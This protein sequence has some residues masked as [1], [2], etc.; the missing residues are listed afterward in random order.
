MAETFDYRGDLAEKP[1]AIQPVSTILI[2]AQWGDEGKGKWVDIL[3]RTADFSIRFQG[4]NNAGH[5]LYIDG[6][7]VVL[8][9]IPSG[10]F[11]QNNISV[12]SCGVV[13]NPTE[14]VKEMALAREITDINPDKIWIS[15]RSHVITPWHIYTDGK[16]EESLENPIG[17]TKRGIGPTY[18]DKASRVGMRMKDYVNP[19]SR[20]TWI[21]TLA[22]NNADFAK[23][24]GQNTILWQE[25]ESAAETLK[26]Y[27][28]DAEGR[29]R[30]AAARGKKLLLEGAQGTLLDI[31]HGTYPYVTSSNT[32]A[33]G[34]IAN[35][36]LS[37]RAIDQVLGI[38]KAYVTR[39][40]GGPFPSELNDAIG[41]Q[42]CEKGREYGATTGRKRRCGWFDAV[43]MR[44]A[45]DVN[46]LDGIYLNKMD[47]LAGFSEVKIC[48][49]YQHPTLGCLT[50]FPTDLN[51][52]AEVTPNYEVLEGW[53]ESD[54]Q[55]LTGSLDGSDKQHE[56]LTKFVPMTYIDLPLTAQ[57]FIRRIEQLIAVPVLRVGIGPGRHD[58]LVP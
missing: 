52:L 20:K 5:T 45:V 53:N 42:L 3:G 14:L 21:A 30:L 35:L 10:I 15:G 23:H 32:T 6:K 11:H 40:G 56:S 39:V 36:G 50:E 28:C 55:K 43:A 33:G 8:H 19:N 13:I 44:Y 29:L 41:E 38:A 49:S 48:V 17:T 57:K 24:L 31:N 47:I 37:H 22:K 25:F 18:S 34:A 2:G 46:G 26:D 16:N 12:L 7:K 9:Q 27:I 4:G 58:F 1:L 54:I 51:L